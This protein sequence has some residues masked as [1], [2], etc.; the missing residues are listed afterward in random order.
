MI[1]GGRGREETLYR[2]PAPRGARAA[3]TWRV[4]AWLALGAADG[5]WLASSSMARRL[6]YSARLGNPWLVRPWYPDRWLLAAFLA[7]VAAGAGM[8]LFAAS[9]RGALLLVPVGVPLLLA[10]LGPLYGPLRAIAWIHAYGRLPGL[11]AIAR[12]AEAIGGIGML[13]CFASTA[14]YGAW[15]LGR[16]RRVGG[17]PRGA[18]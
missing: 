18:P 15:S 12:A 8:A 9:R 7:V 6:G 10:S 2:L 4:A 17:P 16:L 5:G 11:A 13:A 3:V 14:A 1:G